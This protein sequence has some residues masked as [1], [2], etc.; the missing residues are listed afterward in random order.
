MASSRRYRDLGMAVSGLEE[1]AERLQDVG[2]DLKKTMTEVLENTG[3]E[4][5]SRTEKAVQNQ[6]LPRKGEYSKGVTA[7]SVLTD[8]KVRW[9]GPVA[10][11]N[12]GFDKTKP[13][14]GGWLI[15]GTPRM[16]PDLE[17]E[18]IFGGW[19]TQQNKFIKELNADAKQIM[20]DAIEEAMEGKK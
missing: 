8:Q 19:K 18:K 4:I 2:G 15:T 5:Q 13:G 11:I 12:A 17:L 1:L 16:R 6:N 10:S 3:S 14:A 9:S 7:E 20:L